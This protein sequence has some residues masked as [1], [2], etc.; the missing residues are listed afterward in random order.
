MEEQNRRWSADMPDA[1]DR[2]MVPAT[3][4]PFAADLAR[5]IAAKPSRRVLEVAAGTGVVTKALV[6]LPG[7][8]E[9]VA[10]D[11]NPGMVE[12]GRRNVPG[13]RWDTADAL[14]LPFNSGEFD[15]VV[16]QFGVMFFPDKVAGMAEA[17]RVL[18]TGGTFYASTWGRLDEHEVEAAYM[19]AVRTVL[20]EDPPDFL[21]IVPHGYADAD[22]FADDARAAGFPAV[23]VETVTVLNNPVTPRDAVV[24]YCTGS[25]MRAGLEAR[26]DLKTLTEAIATE[27]ERTLG[28]DPVSLKMT[29]HVLTASVD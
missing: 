20:P 29:A 27:A 21:A 18:A 28:T 22:R 17:R 12:T 26:G 2:L 3:F 19:A 7:V 13:A 11:L 1:Y 24:G 10:T 14:A 9:V 6:D 4:E 5:R 8:E 16:C 25:P 23:T 15:A